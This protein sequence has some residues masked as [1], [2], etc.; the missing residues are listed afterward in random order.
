[1][2]GAEGVVSVAAN[3]APSGMAELCSLVRDGDAEAAER[4]NSRLQVVYEALAL[5]TNPIPVKYALSEM[6]L[7]KN[8][9]RLPLT[10]LA[11][12]YRLELAAAL[13]AAEIIK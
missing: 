7:I 12:E 1:L 3:I 13:K 2:L 6:G 4:L 9:I 10:T 11:D 5:Q 8:C